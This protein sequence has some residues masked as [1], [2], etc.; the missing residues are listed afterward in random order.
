MPKVTIIGAG[1]AGLTAALRLAERGYDVTI[2]ERDHNVIG[3]KFRATQW[4]SANV[5]KPPFH[6]HS[7][8]MF[9]NWYHN[10]QVI[11]RDIGAATN[12]V[13]MDNVKFLHAGHFP[14]MNELVNFGSLA[15]VPQNLISGV[16]PFPDMLLY[17]YSVLDLLSTPMEHNRYRDDISVNGFA[18]T[19]PYA[20]DTSVSMYDEYLAKTFAVASYLTSVKSFQTFV[21]YGSYHPVPLYWALN[22]DSYNKFLSLLQSKLTELGVTFRFSREA[23]AMTLGPDRNVNNVTFWV[24]DTKFNPSHSEMS[25]AEANRLPMFGQSDTPATEDYAIDGP[26]ILAVPPRSLQ[27]LLNPDILNLNPPLGEAAKLESVPMASV[28]LHLKDKFASRLKAMG[29]KLP[30]EP[31]ILVNSNYKLSFIAD[32]SLWSGMSETYL[33]IVASDSRPL[34]HLLAPPMYTADRTAKPGGPGLSIEKPATTLDHILHEF[35]RYVPFEDDEIDTALLQIDRNLGRELF[36]NEVGTWQWRP[37]TRT[38]VKNLFLAGDFCKTFID[39]VCL[40]GAAVSGLLAAECVRQQSGHGAPI[41]ILRPR[42]HPHAYYWPAKIVL[43]PYAVWA[44]LWSLCNTAMGPDA[45]WERFW[46]LCDTAI[47][48]HRTWGKLSAPRDAAAEPD[49]TWDRLWS[50][51]GPAPHPHAAW[52]KLWSLCLPRWCDF[53]GD[54]RVR[55]RSQTGFVQS[56]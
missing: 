32:S 13:P 23:R 43:A 1:I 19:R 15:S 8:H 14:H 53:P 26:L 35:R 36:I 18:S 51:C 41:D 25:W 16:L 17:M 30:P 11:A 33:N 20:T 44:K 45:A 4:P 21:E 42:K 39:V 52:L 28:H 34:N 29:T 54:H 56:P 49:R 9:L 31:V 38:K 47:E 22:G 12:F 6:E 5:T 10:F 3:G 2:F 50:L 55:A 27:H 37:E 48:P 7:Y 40:E 46:S 24:V